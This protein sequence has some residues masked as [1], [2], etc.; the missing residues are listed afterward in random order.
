MPLVAVVAAAIFGLS[1]YNACKIEVPTGY[2][3]ILIRKVGT[4]LPNEHV[5]APAS[6][7]GAYFKGIQPG[8]LTEGR[9][10]YNPYFWAWE[11]YPQKVIPSGK[12]AVRLSMVGEELP[13]GQILAEEGQKGIRRKVEGPGRYPYN[14]YAEDFEEHEP[15]V[16]PPGY[17]GVVTLL[18][19]AEPK[20]PNVTLVGK[21]ER[22]V[23][24]E[25]LPPGTYPINPYEQRIGVVDCRS[26][27][28]ATGGAGDDMTFLSSDGF[29]VKLDL[30]IEYR[31][32][33]DRVAEVFVLYNEDFNG[34]AIDEEI[35]SKIITP[36]SRSICRINGSKLSGSEFIGGET[37]T[38]F[39]DQLMRTI[40]TNCRTQGIEILPD[41]V[42]ITQIY[43]PQEIAD[44]VR[45]REVAKQNLAL[46]QQQRDQQ[47]VEKQL[48]VEMMMVKRKEDL[49]EADRKVIEQTTRAEQEQSVAVTKA[50]Q[51]LAVSRTK[52]EAA[53]DLAAAIVSEAEAEAASIRFDNQAMLAGLKT[54]VEAFDGNGGALAQNLL[55]TKLAPAYR[56]ILT[57]SDGPLMDIFRQM[58]TGIDSLGMG[59]PMSIAQPRVA[60]PAGVFDPPPPP[61]S[62]P[63]APANASESE[64][65]R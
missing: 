11:I 52:L 7:A 10:F 51:K 12:L 6:K 30:T 47:E 26:R 8:V 50:E 48:Q 9:Y 20:D 24:K 2:Q 31:V 32:I 49:V 43:P 64:G 5:I 4:N 57:N 22:G 65:S 29:E 45:L 18:T 34:D 33:E 15:V 59:A 55:V 27:R 14:K 39:R 63:P 25:T 40:T 53:R 44:P 3:A 41:G 54:Q 23:Q 56:T 58:T 62:G 42:S 37:R 46:F 35:V 1:L 61:V 28:Y 21:G 36:E 13:T 19:G 38:I 16:I 60:I 17:R